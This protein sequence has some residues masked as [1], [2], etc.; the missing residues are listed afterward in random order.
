MK[1][2]ERRGGGRGR[3]G[4]IKSSRARGKDRKGR[5]SGKGRGREEEGRRRWRG[6]RYPADEPAMKP[7]RTRCLFLQSMEGYIRGL[8]A[9]YHARLLRSPLSCVLAA[10]TDEDVSVR[11]GGGEGEGSIHSGGRDTIHRSV[12]PGGEGGDARGEGIETIH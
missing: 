7:R 10:H 5:R 12:S 8:M 4:E 9:V 6:R 11:D 1:E 3:R 2:E